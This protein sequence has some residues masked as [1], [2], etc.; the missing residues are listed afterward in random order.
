M[1]IKCNAGEYVKSD[2]T[3][4]VSSCWLDNHTMQNETTKSCVPCT[5]STP[6]LKSDITGC[7]SNCS[8]EI[9]NLN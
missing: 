2:N 7:V 4:C 9:C 5:G 3:G 8:D 1:C 6:Y